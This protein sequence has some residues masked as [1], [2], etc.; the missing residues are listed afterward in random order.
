[1]SRDKFVYNNGYGMTTDIFMLPIGTTFRVTN[2]AW[3]GE[4]VEEEGKKMIHVVETGRKYILKEDN[5]Y[6]LCLSNVKYPKGDYKYHGKVIDRITDGAINGEHT[7]EIHFKD[8]TKIDIIGEAEWESVS[9]K[10]LQDEN[11]YCEEEIE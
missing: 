8:G 7:L 5:D 9:L 10:I 2:G 11:D 3:N 1:V 6:M 4:I